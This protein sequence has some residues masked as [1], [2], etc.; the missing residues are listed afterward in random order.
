MLNNI[1]ITGMGGQGISYISTLLRKTAGRKYGSFTGSDNR[2]GAQRFGH[3]SS[4][5]RFS[6]S[7]NDRALSNTAL[8]EQKRLSI[9]I[10]AF[11]A[12]FIIS[13]EASEALNF[14]QK[15][16]SDTSFIINSYLMPPTNIRRLDKPF[17]TLENL[18]KEYSSISK[19][20]HCHNFND[21]AQ[22]STGSVINANIVMLG[23]Y[24]ALTSPLFEIK[25]FI[26]TASK[27][28]ALQTAHFKKSLSAGF[29][30]AMKNKSINV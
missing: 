1:I 20:V 24:I 30:L 9:E 8:N 6:S 4:V 27:M 2:G 22:K 14:I 18:V 12:G 29:E 25:D 13:M 23:F 28:S 19:H 17:F 11:T 21:L 3:V 5:I 15:A 26:K 10:P 7:N 16:G